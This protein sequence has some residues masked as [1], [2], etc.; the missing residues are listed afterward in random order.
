[1]S[2][3][4]LGLDA[5]GAGDQQLDLGQGGLENSTVVVVIITIAIGGIVG[6][7]GGGGVVVATRSTKNLNYRSIG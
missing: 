1:M 2:E 6:I 7:G 4:Y 3:C 5:H